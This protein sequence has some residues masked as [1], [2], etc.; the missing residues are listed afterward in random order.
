LCDAVI[1]VDDFQRDL[2]LAKNP[3]VRVKVI[4]NAVDLEML[5]RISRLPP[6]GRFDSP[7]IVIAKHLHRKCG[8]HVAIEAYGRCRQ[9]DRYLLVIIGNGPERE[10]LEMLAEKVGAAGRVLFPGNLPHADTLR[11]IRGASLSL[12]PSVPVGDYVEATSLTMLESLGM[13]VPTIASDIGGLRQ[14]LAGTGAGMLVEAGNAERLAAAIDD[15]LSSEELRRSMGERGRKLVA[16]K[17]STGP[18]FEAIRAVYEEV[19]GME[20]SDGHG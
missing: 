5:D 8:I 1:A 14:V 12:I 18:W 13:G 11:L 19:A 17:Y 16:E 15:V 10:S 2:V 4:P 6:A 3:S 9:K 20:R 7:Y